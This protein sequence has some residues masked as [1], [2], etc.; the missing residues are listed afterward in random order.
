MKKIINWIIYNLLALTG[1][2]YINKYEYYNKKIVINPGVLFLFVLVWLILCFLIGTITSFG[3]VPNLSEYNKLERYR[4]GFE[5]GTIGFAITY[6]LSTLIRWSS[7][8]FVSSYKIN[9][10]LYKNFR[11]V[12]FIKW[13]LYNEILKSNI[14]EER[15]FKKAKQYDEEFELKRE[16]HRL[17]N[18]I[19]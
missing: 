15:E 3:N 7:D 2:V 10:K 18:K 17:V 4:I 12:P 8:E 6:I 16:L 13:K 5:I 19:N 11:C 9:G 1:N 14:E